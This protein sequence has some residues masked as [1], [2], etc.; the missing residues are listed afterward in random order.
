MCSGL[1]NLEEFFVVVVVFVLGFEAF[2]LEP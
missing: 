1:I 2:T